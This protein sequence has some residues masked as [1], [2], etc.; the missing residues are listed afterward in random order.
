MW[1]VKEKINCTTP[2]NGIRPWFLI[3]LFCFFSPTAATENKPVVET[4]D[5][6]IRN[7]R[8]LDGAANPWVSVDIA[9]KDGRLAKIGLIPERGK[10]EIDAAGQYVSPGWI[11]S[12]DQSG[13]VLL[14]N[15][16]AY[17]KLLMGVT[18]VVAGE[19]GTPV[20]ADDIRHYFSELERR[21]I[22]INFA[23]YYNATQA[24]EE[25]MGGVSRQPTPNELKK[26]QKKVDTAMQAGALGVST[27]LIYPPATF[28][29]TE[30]LIAIVSASAPYHGIYATHLRDEGRELISAIDEAIE[31]GEKA[32]V[33]VE[34]FHLKAAF[35]PGWGTLMKQAGNIIEAARSRGVDVAA[36]VYP[37]VA[38]GTILEVSLPPAV[39][40][41]GRH[42]ALQRLGDKTYRKA[43][44][45]RIEAQDFGEWS[46]LN[47]IASSG[48]W[49]GVVLANPKNK[50]YD[51][52]RLRSIADSAAELAMDPWE[53]AWDI[54]VDA[55][56]EYPVAF[57]FMMSEEDVRTALTFPWTS[58]GSDAGASLELGQED[59]LGL[60]HPRAYGT[61]P[62]IIAEY[63]R[64]HEV[65]T[66]PEA[67]RK[68]A[69]WPASR[70]GFSD[71]GILREGLWAD[72]VIFD[73]DRI[74]DKATWDDGLAPAVGINFVL[75]NGK[76]VIDGGKHSG[77]VPGKVLRGRGCKRC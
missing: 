21:G 40:D 38:A 67:I 46:E 23:S 13:E 31:I 45:K 27:Q 34:I 70:L 51:S 12:M 14:Q 72:I 36:N 71:R 22:S 3:T 65:L 20:A 60:P 1:L 11:D 42:K 15:G 55:D 76:V 66:L 43:L 17:N 41:Q 74:E 26:M 6:V 7:G 24:R 63:V 68:M 44:R 61:F 16:L 10:R 9:I 37:Y 39:F 48:G 47:L 57:F 52:F 50:K 59:A 64:K 18:T 35:K 73:Y 58:I 4:Y 62:R 8:V 5:V 69:S 19:V 2:F 25:V 54:F 53:F 32:G 29:S 56:G 33:P 30:E 75:V 49:G 77:A 28:Q